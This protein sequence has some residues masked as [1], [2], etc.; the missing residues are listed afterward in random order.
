MRICDICFCE[1]TEDGS[2]EIKDKVQKDTCNKCL[3]RLKNNH[4]NK[5]DETLVRE[6]IAF[7]EE[8][9][10]NIENL[11]F[12]LNSKSPNKYNEILRIDESYICC[13]S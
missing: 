10:A 6:Y 5:D 12:K 11:I 13:K 2:C 4:T 8:K 1:F 9:Q 7:M 3:D